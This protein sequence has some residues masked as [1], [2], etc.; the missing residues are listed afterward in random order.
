[1]AN[2]DKPESKGN[3]VKIPL[4]EQRDISIHHEIRKIQDNQNIPL[5][6]QPTVDETTTPP[7]GEPDN[8]E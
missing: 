2:Q 3:E 4:I 6:W 7:K 1:M 5:S 8:E